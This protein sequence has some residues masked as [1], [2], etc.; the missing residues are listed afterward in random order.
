[1]S[2]TE[3]DSRP[4]AW[5]PVDTLAD[6]ATKCGYAAA[7]VYAVLRSFDNP[8]RPDSC[9][10]S[11]AQ[12]AERTRMPQRTVRRYIAALKAAGF[13]RS[14]A[15]MRSQG[16]GRQ[17]NV[18]HFPDLATNRPENGQVV[19]GPTGQKMDDQPARKWTTN[20]PETGQ[21][22]TYGVPLTD[23]E[24]TTTASKLSRTRSAS[25]AADNLPLPQ[26]V[27]DFLRSKTTAK[28]TQAFKNM[29][30][31]GIKQKGRRG[32]TDALDKL[33]LSIGT[34]RQPNALCGFFGRIVERT[35]PDFSTSRFE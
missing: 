29:V 27:A 1:M 22:G 32:M 31:A 35:E 5:L 19:N 17:S 10:P 11:E 26:E 4:C 12:L 14:E 8:K 23:Q 33:A 6:I 16:R 13:V 9:F 18:Y 2:K 21:D 20:R 24:Q 34:I 15:R 25:P 7:F 3:K 28:T 30:A